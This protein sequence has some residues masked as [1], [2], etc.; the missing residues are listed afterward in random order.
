M[1]LNGLKGADLIIYNLLYLSRNRLQLTAGQIA[2]LTCYHPNTVFNTLKRL[3]EMGLIE[4]RRDRRG[5]QYSYEVK[6]D[7]ER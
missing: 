6:K 5:Q 4:R 7:S 1:I 2:Y 3:E